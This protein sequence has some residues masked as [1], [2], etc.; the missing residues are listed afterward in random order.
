MTSKCFNKVPH[1]WPINP[2]REKFTLFRDFSFSLSFPEKIFPLHHP[3]L[4]QRSTTVPPAGRETL[5]HNSNVNQP[6]LAAAASA[7]AGS[8]AVTTPPAPTGLLPAGGGSSAQAHPNPTPSTASGQ[9]GCLLR[10]LGP[11]FSASPHAGPVLSA[12]DRAERGVEVAP[13]PRPR[14]G[15][16]AFGLRP[17]ALPASGRRHR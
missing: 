17:A 13:R 12:P 15:P 7:V 5:F 3:L 16:L 11:A 14:S 10:R 4:S 9:A 6:L 1:G 8:R 2:A